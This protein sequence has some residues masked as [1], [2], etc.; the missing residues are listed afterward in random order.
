MSQ[1]E[2]LQETCVK[3]RFEKKQQV[4]RDNGHEYSFSLRL[5]NKTHLQ[6]LHAPYLGRPALILHFYRCLNYEL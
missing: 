6:V 1:M 4:T 5:K 2:C 3:D